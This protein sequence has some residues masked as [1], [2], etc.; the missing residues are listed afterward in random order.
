M[1]FRLGKEE[2]LNRHMEQSGEL[3]QCQDRY[4]F[5]AGLDLR[6]KAFGDANAFGNVLERHL[7]AEAKCPQSGRHP[8]L[9]DAAVDR[10]VVILRCAAAR[11][12]ARRFDP[13]SPLPPC[14]V[15]ISAL[16]FDCARERSNKEQRCAAQPFRSVCGTLGCASSSSLVSACAA[17]I[18]IVSRATAR[19]REPFTPRRSFCE[20]EGVK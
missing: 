6:K 4:T 11:G 13:F 10:R 17:V 3:D 8:L 20:I 15:L 19:C 2:V 9:V 1:I 14:Q 18:D 7:P 16:L 5:L 12:L